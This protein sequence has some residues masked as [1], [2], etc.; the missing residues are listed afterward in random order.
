M[1]ELAAQAGALN[2]AAPRLRRIPSH[3]RARVLQGVCDRL[4]AAREEFAGLLCA[5]VRK[6]IRDARR[7]VDRAAFTFSWAAQE[8]LRFGGEWL[9]LDHDPASEGR[10]ALVR[11]FPRGPC[12]FITPFNFPLNLVAHKAAPAMAVGAPFLLK[13]APQAPRT[14]RRLGEL[15]LEAGWPQEG[16]A[17]VPCSNEE[18]EAL[19]Q[20][21][22]F[23]VL[24]FTGSAKVGWKLKSLAGRKHVVLELGGNAC[25]LVCADA[26]LAWAAARCAMGAFS[27]AG[28]VCISVQRILVEAPV[29]DDFKRLFLEKTRALRV[30]PPEDES[31]DVGPLIDA[32]AAGRVEAWVQEAVS[33]GARLV[34]GGER[35]GDLLAPAVLEGVPT[36]CRLSCEEAFGPVVGLERFS[37]PAEALRKVS[38]GAYGLQAGVFTRDIGTVL[39]AWEEA[40]VGGVIV[41]DVPTFRSDAMPY[42]GVK[43]SGTGREGVRW[44]MAEFTEPRTLVLKR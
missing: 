40:E 18:A 8:A 20:D 35:R 6:P 12:L 27:Y 16:F 41:N 33:G 42:G 22:R 7:E 26:D 14:A 15:L 21:E 34:C 17:V 38:E 11:R 23:A 30:G 5:E 36:G 1:D 25:A 3:E 31:T 2:R 29:Y 37:S 19:V 43:L 39:G 13:P 28:Q 9:P 24:S 10:L 32:A 44:A 4:K